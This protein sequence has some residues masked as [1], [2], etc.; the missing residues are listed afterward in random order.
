MTSELLELPSVREAKL[1][2]RLRNDKVRCLTCERRCSIEP[3]RTGFCRDR[4]NIDGKLCTLVYG[5]INVISANPIEKKP[6]FHFYP[7]SVALTFSTWSCNF[8][9]PWCQNWELS[10]YPPEPAKANYVSPGRMI[11]MAI[12]Y[13]CDGVSVSFTEP[14]MLFEYS[15]DLF[16]MARAKGLYSNYVSNGYMTE[17]ALRLLKEAGMD[18]IKFDIKG[19]EEVVREYCKADANVVWRNIRLAR[20]LGMHV[21]VVNLVITGL[22]DDEECSRS[23]A[24]MHLKEAGPEVPIH[25]TRFWPAYRMTNRSPTSVETLE[26]AWRVAREEGCQFVYIGNVPGHRYEDTWCPECG[27]LLIKRY[28]FSVLKYKIT[29]DRRC[30]RCRASVPIVG[31]YVNKPTLLPF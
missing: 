4:M 2:E 8:A 19:S 9:C 11:Q 21:E 27:E 25:F 24:R 26:R 31:H 18:A 17:E 3:Q 10:K 13:D 7:G 16:P 15:L 23:I 20:E 22:N 1:Y 12:E 28:G 6:F 5:D 14:L 29:R 30:P